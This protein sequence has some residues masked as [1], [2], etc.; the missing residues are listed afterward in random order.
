MEI[1]LLCILVSAY[2]YFCW[3]ASSLQT[4]TNNQWSHNW[5]VLFVVHLL[6]WTLIAAIVLG[7]P[8]PIMFLA[9][10][11]LALNVN[12]SSAFVLTLM[13]AGATITVIRNER[14]N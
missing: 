13:T 5:F 14:S 11:T 12:T 6:L 10:K 8:V 9:K 3:I 2:F 4:M 7:G 1:L